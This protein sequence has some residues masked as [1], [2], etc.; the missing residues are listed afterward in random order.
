MQ[1]ETIT[2]KLGNCHPL[3]V[4]LVDRTSRGDADP[5]LPYSFEHLLSQKTYDTLKET[6]NISSLTKM[7]GPE[8]LDSDFEVGIPQSPPDFLPKRM[9]LL[10]NTKASPPSQ[11]AYI[12]E[13]TN[14]LLNP[15]F[16]HWGKKKWIDSLELE[17]GLETLGSLENII[18]LFPVSSLSTPE[19][20][21][22][23][24]ALPF[25]DS[26]TITS[27]I[28]KVF[29]FSDPN[30]LGKYDQDTG[31][32]NVSG[33]FTQLAFIKLWYKPTASSA[34]NTIPLPPVIDL[35]EEAFSSDTTSVLSKFS[36]SGTSPIAGLVFSIP[37][38][39][40][41]TAKVIGNKLS[42]Q[43]IP[44]SPLPHT[45]NSTDSSR[46]I[47][48]TG[49]KNSKDV[50]RLCSSKGAYAFPLHILIESEK[51]VKVD[52]RT[53]FCP[54]Y[55]SKIAR[56]SHFLPLSDHSAVLLATESLE[57]LSEK[58]EL[59]NKSLEE[60]GLRP[61]ITSLTSRAGKCVFYVERKK[62]KKLP[63]PP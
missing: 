21:F 14:I 4:K 5:P 36:S 54:D 37:Q 39:G 12:K 18:L 26:N 41:E 45:G 3:G 29:L 50:A 25:M 58:I 59:C 27:H 20:F 7:G 61:L 49:R 33:L 30:G 35:D 28:E 6:L 44:T 31:H 16:F 1:F 42:F 53:K 47:P 60:E 24:N 11:S 8:V 19:N 57:T 52:F 62:T 13:G 23:I 15:S 22:L 17:L 43:G 38:Q 51:V 34:Q 32:Y 10:E 9:L 2:N 55:L 48:C 46:L 63:P 56:F 40:G